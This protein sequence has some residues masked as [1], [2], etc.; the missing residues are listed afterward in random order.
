MYSRQYLLSIAGVRKL[1][2]EALKALIQAALN[3]DKLSRAEMKFIGFKFMTSKFDKSE[4]DNILEELYNKLEEFKFFFKYLLYQDNLDCLY[5]SYDF[6]GKISSEQRKKDGEFLNSQFESWKSII[7]K[8]NHKNILLQN[9]S[10]ETRDLITSLTKHSISKF[11]GSNHH[12]SIKKNL[13]LH[14][15]FIYLKILEYYDEINDC[16]QSIA[17]YGQTI[18]IDSFFYCHV[19][20]GHFAESQKYGRLG[21]TYFTEIIDVDNLPNTV[22]DILRIY[23]DEVSEENFNG[24]NIYFRLLDCNYS[25]WLRKQKGYSYKDIKGEFKLVSTFYPVIYGSD[26]FNISKLSLYKINEELSFYI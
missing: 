5:D 17:F 15:K 23:Q 12:R 6:Y 19:L 20:L 9:L 13:V 24:N 22:L 18:V 25:I 8:P 3:G 1:E 10:K 14:S 4:G 21:K 26:T 7:Y 2:I 11:E 16:K